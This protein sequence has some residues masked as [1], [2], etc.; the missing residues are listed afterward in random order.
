MRLLYEGTDITKD[1]EINKA[2]IVDAAGGRADSLFIR[3]NDTQGLWSKWKPEKNQRIELSKMGFSSGEMYIDSWEIISGYFILQALSVP[4]QAKTT[5]SRS[6]EGICLMELIQEVAGRYGLTIKT[7]GIENHLYRRVEQIN[8]TDIEFL[9]ERCRLE[10]YSL[11]VTNKSL[12]VFDERAMEKEAPV[13]TLYRS[14]FDDDYCF[15]NHST[16]V[17]SACQISYGTIK[18]DTQD[19][20]FGPVKKINGELYIDSIGEAK[21]FSAGIL[22]N[23]NKS[24]AGGRCRIKFEPGIAAGNMVEIKDMGMADGKYF[25]EEI[26]HDLMAEKTTLKLRRPLEGY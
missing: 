14:D 25:C 6:W 3:F 21:R 4:Q 22:R 11:K 8:Q 23:L 18:A 2:I 10:G 9:S 5:Y 24:Y 1:V 20:V 17:F 26:L 19:P 15:W 16:R 12:V 13:K 7:Y